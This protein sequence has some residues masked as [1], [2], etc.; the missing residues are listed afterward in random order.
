MTIY[1]R[2]DKNA[3]ELVKDYHSIYSTPHILADEDKWKAALQSTVVFLALSPYSNEQQDMLH[4]INADGN[5]EKL[6]SCR[7]VFV[8]KAVIRRSSFAFALTS[9]PLAPERPSSCCSR[10]KLSTTPWLIKPS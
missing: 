9:C 7:Y 1:H 6:P 3:F 4:R 10:K 2:H 5:L 8:C